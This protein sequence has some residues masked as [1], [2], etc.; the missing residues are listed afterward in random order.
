MPEKYPYAGGDLFTARN[1]YFYTEYKGIEFLEAWSENRQGVLGFLKGKISVHK[2]GGMKHSQ[3]G[4]LDYFEERLKREDV[5]DTRN[6]LLTIQSAFAD[7]NSVTDDLLKSW[8]DRLVKKFEISKRI[9][10]TYG[11]E[12]MA[13]DK[14]RHKNI[15]LYVSLAEIFVMAYVRYQKLPYLN[16]LL[17]AMDTL[18][19]K[20]KL[21]SPHLASRAIVLFHNEREFVLKIADRLG[22]LL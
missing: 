17:K 4:N 5:I 14:E 15:S 12:F 7:S 19:A 8:V 9:H 13:I 22:V 2:E 3:E 20:R 6:L 10:E 11:R 18:S 16:V 1:T 21:L